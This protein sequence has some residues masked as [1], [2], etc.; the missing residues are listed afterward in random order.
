[1]NELKFSF[2]VDLDRFA[3]GKGR[4]DQPDRP[5][6]DHRYRHHRSGDAPVNG[7]GRIRHPATGFFPRPPKLPPGRGFTVPGSDTDSIA[8]AIDSDA[9]HAGRTIDSY[10]SSFFY[11]LTL[12][13]AR[14]RNPRL[15]RTTRLAG[16]VE[17]NSDFPRAPG[18]NAPKRF[19]IPWRTCR[20]ARFFFQTSRYTR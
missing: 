1:V 2:N 17:R 7:R 14:S 5:R 6:R 10:R 16:A 11:Q 3:Q 9:R 13:S 12:S 15:L 8:A 20:N 18:R 19:A 4:R